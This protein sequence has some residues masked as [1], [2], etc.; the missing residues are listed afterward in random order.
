MKSWRITIAI[1]G[2]LAAYT[3]QVLA[4]D[5]DGRVTDPAALSG[6]ALIIQG[7]GHFCPRVIGAWAM[8]LDGAFG[9]TLNVVCPGSTVQGTRYKVS[10]PSR[11]TY[12]VRVGG[13]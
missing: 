2:I 8:G 12:K 11:G 3:Q 13:W 10:M 4:E 1:L 7:N 5:A 6:L 9:P